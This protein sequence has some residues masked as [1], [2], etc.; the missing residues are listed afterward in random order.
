[1]AGKLTELTEKNFADVVATGAVLV[2]FWAPWCGP[3]RMQTPILEDLAGDVAGACVIA[4]VNVDEAPAL[5]A[6]FGVRSIPT[7]ILFK[8]GKAAQQWVGVQQKDVL[9]KAL[10]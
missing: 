8:D 7:L 5:A 6:K 9:K 2:D 4:K 10:A 1:M 3:C